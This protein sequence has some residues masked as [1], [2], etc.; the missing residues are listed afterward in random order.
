SV[1]HPP[2]ARPTAFAVCA[3]FASFSP[4]APARAG[5]P[6]LTDDPD[7]TE[8]GHWEIYAPALEA[9]GKGRDVEGS[10]GV[11]L[12]YGPA[13]N[14]QLTLGLPAAYAHDAS[15]SQ[16]GAGDLRLSAK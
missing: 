2:P 5:P 15:G 10:V 9:A 16:F 13:P 6:F 1:R 12:N 11:E 4:P 3:G 8:T 7:P 14:V